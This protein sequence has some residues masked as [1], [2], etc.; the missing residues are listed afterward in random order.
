MTV[1]RKDISWA[2]AEIRSSRLVSVKEH[3]DEADIARILEI[4]KPDRYDV[5]L[6]VVT[7]LGHVARAFAPH[8]KQVEAFDPDGKILK[9]AE[10]LVKNENLDNINLIHGDIYNLPFEDKF[11]DIITARLAI[12]HLGNPSGLIKEAYRL[13]QPS[14]RL[15][16]AD[17]L[18]PQHTDLQGFLQNLYT[19]LDKSHLK[20]YTLADLEDFLNI[21]NFA[22]DLIEIYPK[23]NNFRTWAKK[24]NVD[25]S[26]A[27]MLSMMLG[28]ASDRAKRHFRVI[29]DEGKIISFVTWM[30]LIRAI[31]VGTGD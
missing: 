9:G 21:E 27:R 25:K 4:A 3:G 5:V 18:A 14:G 26:Q 11:F 6:D 29:E 17:S 28:S 31:P 2:D 13:L 20:S 16:I 12:R 19:C 22:V 10:V 7:G 23:H 15:I 1:T 30:I 8:V 24:H